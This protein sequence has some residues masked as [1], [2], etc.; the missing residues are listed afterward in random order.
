MSSDEISPNQEMCRGGSET[1]KYKCSARL[2]VKFL[3]VLKSRQAGCEN[4]VVLPSGMM[5]KKAQLSPL[6]RTI[7][8]CWNNLHQVRS[9]PNK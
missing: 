6:M 1:Y 7:C 9:T 8:F 2:R 4:N 5:K 3:L